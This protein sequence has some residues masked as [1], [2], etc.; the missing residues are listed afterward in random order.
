VKVSNDAKEA[1]LSLYRPGVWI[2]DDK[3]RKFPPMTVADGAVSGSDGLSQPVSPRSDFPTVLTFDLPR[4]VHNPR[5]L[6][7]EAEGVWPDRLFE[8]LLIGD[9]DSMLHAKTT[10]MVID[11][12]HD[13][14]RIGNFPP[15]EALAR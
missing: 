10:L 1:S 14:I 3:G 6:V 7:T 9:E 8:G 15:T 4:D 11:D 12:S 13:P 2:V 5:L